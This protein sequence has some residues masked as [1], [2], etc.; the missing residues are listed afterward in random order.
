MGPTVVKRTS[1]A[2]GPVSPQPSWRWVGH[3][4]LGE[5]AADYRVAPFVSL[6]AP[7]RCDVLFII[8]AR[9]TDDFLERALRSGTR[10][11]YVPIDAYLT[12]TQIHDDAALLGRCDAVVSHSERLLPE[13][14]PHCRRLRYVEHHTKYRLDPPRGF[15]ERG[16]VL[17]IGGFQ[18]V[19][20][21]L[22]WLRS[23]ALAAELKILTD[24]DN[25]RAAAAASQLAESLQL[26]CELRK[27]MSRVDGRAILP[28]SESMQAAMLAECK[29]ALD[30]KDESDFNQI[31]KPPTKA[32]Q[33]IASGIPFAT[34]HGSSA[35]EYFE[36]RGFRLALPTDTERWFSEEYWRQTHEQAAQLALRLDSTTVGNSYRQLLDELTAAG[37]LA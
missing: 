28:W 11:V 16:Y 34:N 32:Q 14:A 10:V 12:R 27:G 25:P 20:Y 2:V 35:F 33:Y 24:A 21:L 17:W 13:L 6:Q 7:P 30:V 31:C 22:Q 18:Y 23:H 3:H 26:D 29:A 15:K 5:L 1:I 4:I 19:P 36:R 37:D 9:P 8:K